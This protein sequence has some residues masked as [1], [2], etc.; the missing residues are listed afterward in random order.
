MIEECIRTRDIELKKKD[1]IINNITARV[2]EMESR[3]RRQIEHL[4]DMGGR[5]DASPDLGHR[6]IPL[7]KASDGA[8]HGQ[9]VRKLL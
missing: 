6:G 8:L 1:E 2:K 3:E 4:R 7:P 9:W 5:I